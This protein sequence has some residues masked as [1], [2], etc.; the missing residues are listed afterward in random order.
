MTVVVAVGLVGLQHGE[1][2]VVLGADPL[3]AVDPADLE[4]PLHAADQQ[5]LQVQLGG[6]PQEQ[7]D[8]E[9][10]VVGDERP[11]RR[12]AGDRLHRRRLDLDE[13]SL[14]HHPAE[15]GDDLRPAEEDGQRLG[16]AEQVDVPLP[17]A[18]LDVGQPVP[19]LGRRQQALAQERQP[20]AKTVSSP[21][22]V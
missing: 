4:D 7:V 19:L 13:P 22:L 10:V 8:V 9:R 2:G 16:V 1:L 17:V 21:V 3:V 6:D 18:L 14:G 20:S 15:R 12:A 5:P 11:G